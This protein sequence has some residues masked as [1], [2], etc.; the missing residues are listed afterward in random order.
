MIQIETLEIGQS[1]T[2]ESLAVPW[3]YNG[4]RTNLERTWHNHP[5]EHLRR[6]ALTTLTGIINRDGWNQTRLEHLRTY[7]QDPSVLVAAAQFM[8]PEADL[9]EVED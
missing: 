5:H 8:L 2:R 9:E 4:S 6:S 3:G 7:R 1:Y